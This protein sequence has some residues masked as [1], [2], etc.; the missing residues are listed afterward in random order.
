MVSRLQSTVLEASHPK[1]IFNLKQHLPLCHCPKRTLVTIIMSAAGE[2]QYNS[3]RTPGLAHKT[4][5]RLGL[6]FLFPFQNKYLAFS[7]TLGSHLIFF[8]FKNFKKPSSFEILLT[9]TGDITSKR[10]FFNPC[11]THQTD[12]AW[13]ILS[14]KCPS[15]L[16]PCKL[17]FADYTGWTYSA[18]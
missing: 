16:C 3:V 13:S 2:K 9:K 17:F 10:F 1:A 15:T 18:S 5:S 7:I 12:L 11:E 14:L 4:H 6:I 8:L